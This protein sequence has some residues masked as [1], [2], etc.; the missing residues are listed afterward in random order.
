MQV[1]WCYSEQLTPLHNDI[2]RQISSQVRT[3]Q[4]SHSQ[5]IQYQQTLSPSHLQVRHTSCLTYLSSLFTLIVIPPFHPSKTITYLRY[6]LRLFIF[7]H[8]H[9]CNSCFLHEAWLYWKNYFQQPVLFGTLN[10]MSFTPELRRKKSP[11]LKEHSQEVSM[12]I[13]QP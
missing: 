4:S 10:H 3:N 6:T 8:Y 1:N 12:P 2:F 5:D 7:Y 9:N 13:S 11:V